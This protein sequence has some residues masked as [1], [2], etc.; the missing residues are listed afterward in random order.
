MDKRHSC[1]PVLSDRFSAIFISDFPESN[2]TQNLFPFE[3]PSMLYMYN[4]CSL[5]NKLKVRTLMTRFTMDNHI[6]DVG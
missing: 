3:L 4:G 1:P 5:R 2:D 6:K